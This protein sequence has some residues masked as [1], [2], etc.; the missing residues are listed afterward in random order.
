MKVNVTNFKKALQ[1]ATL[2]FS[3]D[4]VQLN[5]DKERVKSNMISGQRDA[6]V[7]LDIENDIFS[8]VENVELNFT[9]PS[10]QLVP[11][12]N[13]I[14][15]EEVDVVFNTEK[16]VLKSGKQKSNIH[17]CSP[18][19]V[20]IFTSK[21][22]EVSNFLEMDIDESFKTVFSKI[23]KIGSRFD[24]IY[25]NLQDGIFSIEST[26]KSNMFS[27]GLKFDLIEDVDYIDLTMCFSYKNVVNLMAILNG[28]N[29][30][31]KFA[32]KKEQEMGMLTVEDESKSERYY[33][34]R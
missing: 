9:D 23:K 32:Y 16:M 10:Q 20:S 14:D 7:F 18:T 19:V 26:D 3:M 33:L 28:E 8:I 29:F 31:M 2:N 4:S 13:L 12:L 11:F 6:I 21:P 34:L 24:D 22:Q 5:V 17:F 30:K 25:F 27:N 1:K 15:E